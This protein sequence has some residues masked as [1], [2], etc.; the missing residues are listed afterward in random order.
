MSTIVIK[1][2]PSHGTDVLIADLGFLIPSSGGS[3]T[4]T[5]RIDIQK[6]MASNDLITL[7][8]DDVYSGT[9]TIILN[10]GTNDIPQGLVESFLGQLYTVGIPKIARVLNVSPYG[11]GADYSS[12]KEACDAASLLDPVPSVTDPVVIMVY[13]G[14]YVESPMTVPSNVAVRGF[15]VNIVAADADATLFSLSNGASVRDLL[16]SGASDTNGVAIQFNGG[17]GESA[18]CGDLIISS[19]TVGIDLLGSPYATLSAYTVYVQGA[20][21]ALRIQA[22]GG[23]MNGVTVATLNTV[24]NDLE[25]ASANGTFIMTGGALDRSKLS[26]ASGATFLSQFLDYAGEQ[27]N[28][29]TTD[30]A[31]GLPSRGNTSSFGEGEATI[32]GMRCKRN[33]NG[34][35]GVWSDVTADAIAKTNFSLFPGTGSGNCFYLGN[36]YKFYDA[37]MSVTT[38][39]VIGSGSV[40]CEYWNGSAWTEFYTMATGGLSQYGN[41]CLTRVATEDVRFGNM[42]NWTQ[43]TL[44]GYNKYW[45][46]M[47]IVTAITTVPVLNLMRTGT[48]KTRIN[49]SGMVE[50]F[51]DARPTKDI[52]ALIAAKSNLIGKLPVSE[53]ILI[54]STLNFD[55]AYNE[56]ANGVQD[57]FGDAISIPIGLDT[58]KPIVFEMLWYVKGTNTGNVNLYL[59]YSTR[60]L[61]QPI[62]GAAPETSIN[63]LVNIATDSNTLLQRTAFDT[64]YVPTLIP[65]DMLAFGYWR[66]AVSANDTCE[67]SIVILAINAYGYLWR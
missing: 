53:D 30:L 66:D 36:D 18:D 50:Y 8:T 7:A 52:M 65:G 51:G 67:T 19:C 17:A 21:T 47:R 5:S 34:T 48:N 22:S 1:T 12:I 25:I 45:V 58:S 44:D 43:N 9:S 60:S 38:A 11:V 24:T 28:Q 6:L 64:A 56:F 3:I 33:T 61:G 59:T 32:V 20:T 41:S 10:N 35:A 15:N 39:M 54:S 4:I 42:T 62:S 27:A 16:I 14:L 46:R 55:R 2:N 31:V 29:V 57:G 40:V 49:A 63:K 26:I 37:N 13:P 23:I